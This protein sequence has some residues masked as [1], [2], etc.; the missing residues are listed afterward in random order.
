MWQSGLIKAAASC[1]IGSA[2]TAPHRAQY[3]VS[4]TASRISSPRLKASLNK[5]VYRAAIRRHEGSCRAMGKP[6]DPSQAF[7]A[8]QAKARSAL[9]EMSTKG[10]FKRTDATYRDHV[11]KGTRFEPEGEYRIISPNEP[12]QTKVLLAFACML[13]ISSCIRKLGRTSLYTVLQLEGIT[14]TLHMPVHGRADAL[15]S[16]I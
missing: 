16:G 14:F 12:H 13:H 2:S 5:P 9:D 6:E 4:K 11:K 10:E 3:A 7:H 8:G 15:Q 1:T